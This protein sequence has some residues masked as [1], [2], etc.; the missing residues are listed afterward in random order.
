MHSNPTPTTSDSHFDDLSS[1][2]KNVRL[3]GSPPNPAPQE[4]GRP[5]HDRS[6]RICTVGFHHQSAGIVQQGPC[7]LKHVTWIG[8]LGLTQEPALCDRA[9]PWLCCDTHG[10]LVHFGTQL[11]QRSDG[12]HIATE[13]GDMQRGL[14][15]GLLQVATI[16]MS[17]TCCLSLTQSV[18][19]HSPSRHAI[20]YEPETRFYNPQS[21]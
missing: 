13:A 2:N 17:T 14:A 12:L 15:I 8:R 9:Q 4:L 5:S 7:S 19:R 6:H 18:L 16:D 1:E 3:H 21:S 11:H 20:I 10:G